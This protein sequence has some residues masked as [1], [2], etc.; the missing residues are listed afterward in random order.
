MRTSPVAAVGAALLTLTACGSDA[1]QG[2][3]GGGNDLPL[4]DTVT[5]V[6]HDSFA[7]PDEVLEAFE[8]E[9]GIT[10]QFVAPGD[11]G[12]LV[13][14]LILTKDAPLGDVVYGVDNTFA[15]RADAEGVFADYT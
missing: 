5:V 8:A 2:P 9:H 1:D 4:L 3:T 13:N 7:V 12:S 14:Q 10:V 6:T 15:S 11:A